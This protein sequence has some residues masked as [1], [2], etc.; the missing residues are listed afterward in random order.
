[1]KKAT[2][3]SSGQKARRYMGSDQRCRRNQFY[4]PCPLFQKLNPRC[5]HCHRMSR[6]AMVTQN[7]IGGVIQKKTILFIAAVFIFMA[8]F[9]GCESKGPAETAGEKIDQ[10]VEFVKEAADEVG[11][12]ISG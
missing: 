10:S 1:M 2:R 11:D 8:A 4:S 5:G 3:L 7:T 6:V 12:E 9:T